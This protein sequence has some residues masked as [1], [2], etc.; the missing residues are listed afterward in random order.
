[1]LYFFENVW[2][3]LLLYSILE[4]LEYRHINDLCNTDTFLVR[5]LIFFHSASI[6]ERF[7]YTHVSASHVG[8]EGL[9]GLG[10]SIDL[11]YKYVIGSEARNFEGQ[12]SDGSINA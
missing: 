2:L 7:D 8:H 10:M 5:T 9:G 1:M 11:F 6:S 12:R 3:K 4:L